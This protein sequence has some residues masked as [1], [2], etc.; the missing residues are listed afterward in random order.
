MTGEQLA[1]IRTL[2]D[3]TERARARLTA[4]GGPEWSARRPRAPLVEAAHAL[5][6]EVER[7]RAFERRIIACGPHWPEAPND[8]D[9]EPTP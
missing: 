5:L 3:D 1:A 2:L 8:D 4:L 6:A 9:G 7:L